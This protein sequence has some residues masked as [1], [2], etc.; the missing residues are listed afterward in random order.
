MLTDKNLYPYEVCIVGSGPAGA[1]LGKSLVDEGIKT[2]I[3]ESGIDKANNAS[4][5]SQLLGLD[6][7]QNSGPIDYPIAESR[8][9]GLG[10]TS[11]TWTGRCPRLHP[12]DFQNNAYTP[13]D[14]VWPISYNEI[15]PYYEKAEKTLR[16]GGVELSNFCPP[17]KNK[18]PLTCDWNR[19][20][21]KDLVNPCR[22]TIDFSPTSTAN[23]SNPLVGLLYKIFGKETFRVAEQILPYFSRSDHGT[24]ITGQTVTKLISDSRGSIIG[25]ETKK[26]DGTVENIKARVYIIA[27]GGIETPRL[28]L[29]SRSK[30]FPNGIGN[31]FDQVGRYF[32]EHPRI[33][34]F[35]KIPHRLSTIYPTYKIGRSYEF[36]EKFKH[37]GLGSV[38]LGFVQS[39]LFSNDIKKFSIKKLIPM[40]KIFLGRIRRAD[41]MISANFEMRP[42]KLNRVTLSKDLK[43]IFGNP[44]ANLYLS[45]TKHDLI[46]L[47]NL[48]ALIKRIYKEIGAEDIREEEISWPHHH[49][50]TCRLGDDPK[51]SVVDRNLRVHQSPNLYIVGSSVFVTGGLL[52]QL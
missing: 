34:Y 41:L 4:A 36:Y 3:I 45:F 51:T 37:K 30:I 6:I 39:W 17:R 48:R 14:V 28:L 16:V 22:I 7:Y 49:M 13:E 18:F 21:L 46:T 24:L 10:G 25:A 20:A 40:I 12:V 52:H 29:L 26:L 44:A 47:E 11:N 32:M 42:N 8:H 50:G 33:I 19:S 2:V 35:G 31:N 9:R 27:C 15:E 38:R 23:N 43:D 5:S 1:I